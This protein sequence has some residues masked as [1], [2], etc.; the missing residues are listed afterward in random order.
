MQVHTHT[1]DTHHRDSYDMFYI[2]STISI[3]FPC[4]CTIINLIRAKRVYICMSDVVNMNV[5]IFHFT[6]PR[7]YMKVPDLVRVNS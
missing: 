4:C 7:K 3:C 1:Y 6:L 2:Q 5:Y